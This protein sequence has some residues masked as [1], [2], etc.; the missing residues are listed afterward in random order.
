MLR[1]VSFERLK[2]NLRNYLARFNNTTSLK[3]KSQIKNEV[4]NNINLASK[5]EEINLKKSFFEPTSYSQMVNEEL[6]L[7]SIVGESFL[8]LDY[9][10]S[11]DSSR[12]LIYQ[13]KLEEVKDRIRR[14]KAK[15][16]M[17]L[18][19]EGIYRK[20]QVE[21]F[22]DSSRIKASTLN[23]DYEHGIV[24]LPISNKNYLQVQKYIIK[25]GSEGVV[26]T[27]SGRNNTIT[28]L[29]KNNK[30]SFSFY[31]NKES[32]LVVEGEF[33][34]GLQVVNGLVVKVSEESKVGSVKLE[35]IR[36]DDSD[37][38]LDYRTEIKESYRLIIAPRLASKF[39]LTFVQDA[40]YYFNEEPIFQIDLKEIYF[41]SHKYSNQ[42]K[43]DFYSF[44]CNP[45]WMYGISTKVKARMLKV[46]DLEHTTNGRKHVGN[47]SEEYFS[48]GLN[49]VE[50]SLEI[51]RKE[52]KIL[53]EKEEKFSLSKER[54]LKVL[55]LDQQEL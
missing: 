41:E 34:G 29:A 40:A 3:D 24:T 33:R 49:S 37:E 27:P 9:A 38:L 4:F 15:M 2:E 53:S 52:I 31:K 18:S 35:S 51:K 21:S 5:Y 13:N 32:K 54:V 11:I 25:R 55:F 42:G 28:V 12:E 39:K 45:E 7:T 30:D 43:L 22:Q 26:G 23:I 14:I 10:D 47:F 36:L 16:G 46:C 48:E 50:S 6:L 20:I 8:T 19:S 44:Q 1:E 17:L